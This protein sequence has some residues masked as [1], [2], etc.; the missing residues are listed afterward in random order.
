MIT[1]DNCGKQF[2]NVRSIYKVIDLGTI[3]QKQWQSVGLECPHCQTFY[4]SY[5]TN[6][7]M[8]RHLARVKKLTGLDRQVEMV[9][10]RSL[11]AKTDQQGKKLFQ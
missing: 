10:I 7:V 6:D 9:K 4:H 5:Y 2:P 11:R 1:C 3:K 8:E